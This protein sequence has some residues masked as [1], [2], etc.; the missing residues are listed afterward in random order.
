MSDLIQ[1][2]IAGIIV[3]AIGTP[4][5]IVFDKWKKEME[6]DESRNG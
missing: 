1:I 4:L 6:E 5:V 3:L 2:I